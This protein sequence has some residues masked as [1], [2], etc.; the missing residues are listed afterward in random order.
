MA[1]LT[2][3]EIVTDCLNDMDSDEVNSIND[4]IESQQVAQIAKSVFFEM[5]GNRNWPHLK[6]LI[7]LESLSDASKPNYLRIPILVK[8]LVAFNYDTFT[9]SSPDVRL[10]E[11]KWKD[12]DAFLRM[13]STRSSSLSTVDSIIDFSGTKLLV[14]NNQSPT[15]YTSFDDS[16]VVT[17]SYDS[18]VDSTL[19][20][21]KT[22]CIAYV[23][24]V[25]V[26]TDAGI[27]NLPSEAFPALLA[28]V[29]SSAFLN[30]KQTVNQKAEQKAGRQNRWLARKA[31]AAN[32]GIT[33]DNYG[34][35]SRK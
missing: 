35:S 28:E 33:Y 21:S 26:H 29:K 2:L 4:T 14:V 24:P 8:E 12:P 11:L 6:K 15:Y 31:W 20:S 22:Q 32:G 5:I 17:D 30:L 19:Q 34:R 16:H 25:W 23:E 13:V 9:T 1:K 18:A 3:L 10:T 7:Q 27:P